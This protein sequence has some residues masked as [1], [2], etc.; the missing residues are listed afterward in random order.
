MTN[1]EKPNTFA[2]MQKQQQEVVGTVNSEPITAKG[3]M[4]IDDLPD[5]PVGEK[6]AYTRP[7]L[8]GTTDVVEKYQ[9]FLPSTNDELKFSRD[10]KTQYKSVTQILTYKSVN[11]DGVQN[12]EYISG[13]LCF[14]QKDGSL[15]T[16]QFWYEGS[17]TQSAL[18]WERVAE[19]LGITP[20]E[21]SPRQFVAFLN[22]KPKVDIAGVEYENYNAE[23]GAP[24]TV[25]KNMPL[26]FT[27]G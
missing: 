5:I 1:Q 10:K 13:G 15:S 21:L 22:S 9:I 17:R 4:S 18:M 12:R 25:K 24:K 6:I 3:E 19:A 8:S 20:L 23:K 26:K 11:D 7:D 2:A 14:I 27:R 16:P